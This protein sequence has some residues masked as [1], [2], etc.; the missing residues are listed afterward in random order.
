MRHFVP[1]IMLELTVTNGLLAVA[2]WFVT[3]YVAITRFSAIQRLLALSIQRG[4]R[5]IA[6]V[7]EDG[8]PAYRVIPTKSGALCNFS[9]EIC[10]IEVRVARCVCLVDAASA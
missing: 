6:A 4:L 8:N 1:P 7:G 2:A 5:R 9:R 3:C 10:T